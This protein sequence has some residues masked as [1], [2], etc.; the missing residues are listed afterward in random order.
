VLNHYILPA[1]KFSPKELLLGITINTLRTEPKDVVGEF[2][3]DKATIHMTYVVQQ[4][5]DGYK[6]MVKHIIVYK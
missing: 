6:A 1:L 4:H 2:S 5:L 3:L